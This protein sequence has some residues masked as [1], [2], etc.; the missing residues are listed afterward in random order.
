M[1]RS[2]PMRTIGGFLVVLLI[3]SSSCLADNWIGETSSG[4]V[5]SAVELSKISGGCKLCNVQGAAC[6]KASDLAGKTVGDVC[7]KCS[8]GHDYESGGCTEATVTSNCRF[9]SSVDQYWCGTQY[10]GTV[11]FDDDGHPQCGDYQEQAS[12]GCPGQGFG[13]GG[14]F[15]GP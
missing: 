12:G 15:C 7:W 2:M 6:Q 13:G 14:S 4:A 11:H 8:G 9:G 3:L 1:E 10:A 5:L